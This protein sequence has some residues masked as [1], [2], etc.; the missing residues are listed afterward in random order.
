MDRLDEARSG[1]KR[2]SIAENFCPV[3]A[4][5]E[6]RRVDGGHAPL[7][8][9]AATSAGLRAHS[10]PKVCALTILLIWNC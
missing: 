8:R 6:R 5:T 1:I 10:N 2:R 3:R 9:L 4:E 7:P